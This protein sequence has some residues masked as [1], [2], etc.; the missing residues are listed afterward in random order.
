MRLMHAALQMHA[1][2]NFAVASVQAW[3]AT[4]AIG[5]DS[6]L[7]VGGDATLYGE[8]PSERRIDQA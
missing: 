4:P 6:S 7:G 8:L 2:I 1:A 3:R 5:E